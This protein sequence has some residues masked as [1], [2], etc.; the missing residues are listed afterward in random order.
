MVV[1]RY[2]DFLDNY[3]RQIKQLED[4]KYSLELENAEMEKNSSELKN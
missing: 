3:E 1:E 2:E 4:D